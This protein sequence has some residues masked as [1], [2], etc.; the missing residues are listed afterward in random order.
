[1]ASIAQRI[2]EIMQ[3]YGGYIPPKNLVVQQF[4]DGYELKPD[5]S[6]SVNIV[7]T[8]VGYLTRYMLFD[9]KEDAFTVPL[10]GA[11]LADR[12]D[13]AREL[14]DDVD[15]LSPIS[16]LAACRLCGYDV[17]VREG[18]TYYTP[19]YGIRPDTDTVFNIEIMVKRTVKFFKEVKPVIGNCI[20]FPGGYTDK[21]NSGTADFMSAGTI[22]DLVVSKYKPTT[23]HT[24]QLLMYA[25]MWER[26]DLVATFP[27][28][29]S[30]GVFNPRLNTSYTCDLS[31]ISERAIKDVRRHV[32]GYAED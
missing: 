11:Q 16:I 24:L 9:D 8:A 19:V 17:V 15:G 7:G 5:E 29:E 30:V 13:E 14:L 6:V 2:K 20:S 3:P 26:C 23:T 4:K 28:V 18:K 22:W 25:L 21:T 1:M 12:E 27:K 32:I 10:L 31:T